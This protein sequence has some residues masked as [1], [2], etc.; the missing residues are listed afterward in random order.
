MNYHRLFILIVADRAW[1][2]GSL[3]ELAEKVAADGPIVREDT[4]LTEKEW[5][6]I[7]GRV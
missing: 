7:L 3:K 4:D 2:N 1:R 6:K 5:N